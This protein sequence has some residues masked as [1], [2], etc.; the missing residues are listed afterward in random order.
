[1]IVVAEWWD[2]VIHNTPLFGVV[3]H[4]NKGEKK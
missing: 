1:M 2:G 3:W 4:Q